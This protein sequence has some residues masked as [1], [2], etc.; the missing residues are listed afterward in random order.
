MPAKPRGGPQVFGGQGLRKLDDPRPLLRTTHKALQLPCGQMFQGLTINRSDMSLTRAGSP[1]KGSCYSASL[2]AASSLPARASLPAAPAH[3]PRAMGPRG[4]HGGG[5]R[6]PPCSVMSAGGGQR[7]QSG[8][9]H[10][11]GG[12]TTT[13][14][15]AT[16]TGAA[17]ATTT[18][19]PPGSRSGSTNSTS[20]TKV[21]GPS[22]GWS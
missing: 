15:G 21:G 6:P 7:T 4:A 19:P 8:P 2:S 5:G 12:T 16:T 20:D 18:S 11:A 3:I 10:M 14:A 17:G 13:G 1:P 9:T 22:N